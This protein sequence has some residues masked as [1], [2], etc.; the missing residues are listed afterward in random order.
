MSKRRFTVSI[1]GLPWTSV[2]Q[3]VVKMP[4]RYVH[5]TKRERNA[6]RN[7]VAVGVAKTLTE[8]DIKPDPELY[9]DI[10]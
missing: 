10:E 1:W 9:G 6:F 7:G 8:L 3:I 4:K 5:G 2:A